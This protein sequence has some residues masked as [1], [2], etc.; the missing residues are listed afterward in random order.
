MN[1]LFNFDFKQ[2]SDKAYVVLQRSR[3]VFVFVRNEGLKLL[4]SNYM[5]QVL[6]STC[7]MWISIFIPM[8]GIMC[9]FANVTSWLS[10]VSEILK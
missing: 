5:L 4:S 6:L 2:N 1:L 8:L 9:P 10:I 7:L 3:L